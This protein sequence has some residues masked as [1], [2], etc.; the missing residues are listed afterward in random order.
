MGHQWLRI[1]KL[2][3]SVIL[4]NMV[5]HTGQ[6]IMIKKK[7]YVIVRETSIIGIQITKET[8]N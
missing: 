1:L 2:V 7:E 3:I 6:A 8:I 5:M 4:D